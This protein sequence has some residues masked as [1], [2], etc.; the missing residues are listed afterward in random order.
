MGRAHFDLQSCTC[1]AHR[2]PVNYD[3]TAQN[4]IFFQDFCLSFRMDRAELERPQSG[5]QRWRNRPIYTTIHL[6]N[7]MSDLL[8]TVI[9]LTGELDRTTSKRLNKVQSSTQRFILKRS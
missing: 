4:Y 3:I 5:E 8:S 6:I 7:N 2:N 9:G 1:T